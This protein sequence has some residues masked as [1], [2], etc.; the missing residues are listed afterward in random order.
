VS[1][2]PITAT[3][4]STALWLDRTDPLAG[5]RDEYELPRGPDGAPLIYLVGN[6]LGLMPKQ[7][8]TLMAEEL[9]Q[10]ARRG[11]EAHLEAPTP[12]YAYHEV[13]RDSG[14]RLVGALPGEVVMMNSLTVN[15]HLMLVS[16]YRPEGRRTRIVMEER[17]FPSDSYAVTSHLRS[18]GLDPAEHLRVLIPRPGESVIR[19]GD[20]LRVLEDEGDTIAL[21]L[22]GGVNFYTG[23]LFEIGRITTA[24][25]QAGA[26]AGFDLA[27]AAGNAVLALHEWEVDFAVWCSYK[28]LN[29]GPGAVAGCFVHERHGKN[30]S[31]PRY[32]GWWGNDPDTRFEM[33][34]EFTPQPGADGWQVSNPSVF[35]M[36]PLRA[37]LALF[38]RAGMGRLR[39]KSESLTGLLEGLL[40]EIPDSP[41]RLLTPAAPEERGCQLSL[42]LPGRG[43]WLH[44]ALRARGIVVDYREPDVVR[45]APVPMYNT[46]HEVW[47]TVQAIRAALDR[48]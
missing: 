34:P 28:Y 24:A 19:T 3:S 48:G 37:S 25:H 17:A 30:L 12:W 8:R 9:D 23:Q 26:Q 1:R 20:I 44:D 2:P 18:R 14:A 27:H 40:R 45:L 5:F 35:A 7:V 33:S 46:H 4:E 29:A 6:S 10:W 38:D 11:V 31:I 15:L 21:V 36:A 16:F 32:A 43:R 42:L 22:L 13:F 39:T 41:L 47:R